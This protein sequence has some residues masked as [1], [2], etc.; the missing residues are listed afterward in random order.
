MIVSKLICG[1]MFF[2]FRD[3]LLQKELGVFIPS[4]Y[5]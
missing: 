4:K 3:Y 2:T 5:C 1:F